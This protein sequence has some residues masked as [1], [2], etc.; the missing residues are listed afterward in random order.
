MKYFD[1]CL[2]KEFENI[3]D[4]HDAAAEIQLWKNRRYKIGMTSGGFDPIHGGHIS[5]IFEAASRCDV[6]FVV[7]NRDNF[8]MQKKGQAFMPIKVRAQVVSAIKNVNFTVPFEPTNPL[9]MTVNE[10]LQIL[11]PH[12]FFKGGDR[13]GESSIPEWSTCKSL[14]IEIIS[15]MGDNKL[16]SSSDFLRKWDGRVKKG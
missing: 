3:L 4:I 7:V 8:L 12:R 2:E 9:D 11:K 1:W 10:A 16:W 15:G 6:L 14:G 13:V 5:C